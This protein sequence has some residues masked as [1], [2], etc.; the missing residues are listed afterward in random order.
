ML[1]ISALSGEE[2]AF[3]D[4]DEV[5][6]ET[7]KTLK[8]R[9]ARR[10][11]VSRFRQRWLSEDSELDDE[12]SLVPAD[13]LLVVLDFAKAHLVRIEELASAS[14]AGHC[15]KVEALLK[16]PLHP[17]CKTVTEDDRHRK[18][19]KGSK[20]LLGIIGGL[21][22]RPTA[23]QL[24]AEK[25]HLNVVELLI[26]A[27]AD[28]NV[29]SDDENG[30]TP[31]LLASQQSHLDVMRLL[32]QAG[33]KQDPLKR[34]SI[35]HSAAAKGRTE[36]V[37]LLL[38]FGTDPNE[39]V[40]GDKTA[41]HFAAANGHLKVMKLLL[42]AGTSTGKEDMLG[43]TALHSAAHAGEQAAIEMLLEAA[44]DPLKVTR[45]GKSA[46]HFASSNGHLKVMKLLLDAG[47]STG[48]E[49]IVGHTALHL[50]A[51][52][53]EQA[54]VEMLLEAA[55]DPLKV[56][57]G[58]KSALDFATENGHVDTAL[59]LQAACKDKS[60]SDTRPEDDSG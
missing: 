10:I 26:D 50:A 14:T 57:R 34:Q 53:G 58:G 37:M 46:L 31:L 60:E 16:L 7:V 27:A 6:G 56:T 12:A 44:A 49:D 28:V 2:V 21:Q 54:A 22:P 13:V 24:A 29:G 35:L 3:F 11:G 39:I 59:L 43:H 32:L 23:L 9:L 33:A 15:D 48:K 51:R 19:R 36:V 17:D 52:A 30:H 45:G 42:D 38:E 25:G 5:E 55:A 8:R 20:I 47:T 1:R 40:T 4:L 41:L 18:M